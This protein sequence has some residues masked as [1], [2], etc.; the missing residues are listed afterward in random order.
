MVIAKLHRQHTSVVMTVPKLICKS[1]GLCAGDYV[2]IEK[3]DRTKVATIK[4]FTPK[5]IRNAND[6]RNSNRKDKGR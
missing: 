3:V 5:D 4:K 2:I 6:K 1:L